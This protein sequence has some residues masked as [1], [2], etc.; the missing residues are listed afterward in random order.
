MPREYF[1]P[2][3]KVDS[4]V[5]VLKRRQTPLI[6]ES[7]VKDF[8]RLLKFAFIAPRKVLKKN[9]SKSGSPGE[10]LY[11]VFDDATHPYK[12]ENKFGMGVGIGYRIFFKNG[13]YNGMY[14]GASLSVGRYISGKKHQFIH[15]AAGGDDEQ[16]IIDVELLKFGYA[17]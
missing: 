17:F 1:A 16:N 7:R 2:P 12:T 14:W 15:D 6:D 8:E 10:V 9:L 13:I 3:P 11:T 4:R 5:I